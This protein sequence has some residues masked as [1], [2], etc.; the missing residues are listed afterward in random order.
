MKAIRVVVTDT[1]QHAKLA[2]RKVHVQYEELPA[3]LSIEEAMKCNSFLPNTERDGFG[4]GI[5]LDVI[6]ANELIEGLGLGIGPGINMESDLSESGLSSNN[7]LLE[8]A[9]ATIQLGKSL[10]VNHNGEKDVVLNKIIYLELK[11]KARITKEGK[12]QK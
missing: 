10:G 4:P 1:Y 3:I 11:D 12:A 5:N 8:E 2:A 7:Y 9:K 6:L